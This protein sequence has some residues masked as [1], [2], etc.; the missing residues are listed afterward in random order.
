MKKKKKNMKRNLFKIPKSIGKGTRKLLILH[1]N[2]LAKLTRSFQM[3]R[4][5]QISAAGKAVQSFMQNPLAE[6]LTWERVQLFTVCFSSIESPSLR[7]L[8][9]HSETASDTNFFH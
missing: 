3:K 2:V 5:K 1:E 4:G 6:S 7:W 9:T 8:C